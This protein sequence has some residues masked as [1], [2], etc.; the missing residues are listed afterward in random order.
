MKRLR[1]TERKEIK[2]YYI[3]S[4]KIYFCLMNKKDCDVQET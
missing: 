4:R 3:Y 1:T 2:Q